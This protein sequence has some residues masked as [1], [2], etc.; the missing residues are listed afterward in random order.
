MYFKWTVGVKNLTETGFYLNGTQSSFY[1][2]GGQIEQC[3]NL[4]CQ[5]VS[6]ALNPC[7]RTQV[8]L[9]KLLKVMSHLLKRDNGNQIQL[10]R[11]LGG[12]NVNPH[13]ILNSF[14]AHNTGCSVNEPL[15]SLQVK[16]HY[17]NILCNK[18]HFHTL[19]DDQK[20]LCSVGYTEF[21]TSDVCSDPRPAYFL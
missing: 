8:S 21:S 7:Y 19:L 20:E 11:L 14:M 9:S 4:E 17:E 1:T 10:I 12:L 6:D 16:S 13:K 2:G 5:L 3:G 18:N 15:L